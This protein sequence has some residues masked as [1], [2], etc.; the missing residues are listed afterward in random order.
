MTAAFMSDLLPPERDPSLSARLWH[1]TVYPV[2]YIRT[3]CHCS[4]VNFA[5]KNY[6]WH[7][8]GGMFSGYGVRETVA[9]SSEKINPITILVYYSGK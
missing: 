3:K 4:F 7:V 8:L 2:W 1:P 5:L 6:Q 9:F